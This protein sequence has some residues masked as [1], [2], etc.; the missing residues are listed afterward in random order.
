MKCS[1]EQCGIIIL[2]A[3]ESKR[4]G[5]PKQ[6]LSIDG[7]TL[8]ARVAKTACELMT[9][10]VIAVLGAHAEKISPTLNIPGITVVNNEDWQEGMASSIIKGLTS[11]VE[12]YPQVDGIIILVCDQPYLSHDLIKALIE[13][14]HNAGLPAAA[15]A[16][17][18]KLGTPALF[19][20]SLFSALMLLSGDKGARKML[21]QMR[22]NVVEVDF[23][24]GDVD[25]DTQADYERLLNKDK[26]AE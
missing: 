2:A 14:Q 10:P 4:L 1:I 23:E 24:M 18:G 7:S 22:E 12:L 13:A 21:E 25:I 8:L 15:A 6:L 11:M 19:H 5:S 26:G 20:K 3:G 17:N 16:Y 9:Y